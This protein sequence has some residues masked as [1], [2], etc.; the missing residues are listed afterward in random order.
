MAHTLT[1][2]EHC[3]E[4]DE[5]INRVATKGIQLKVTPQVIQNIVEKGFDAQYGARSLKRSIQHNLEDIL[6]D[7]LMEQ[8]DFIGTITVDISNGNFVINT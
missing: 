1:A 7:Y 8:P 2:F 5:I 4:I 3:K 6:C